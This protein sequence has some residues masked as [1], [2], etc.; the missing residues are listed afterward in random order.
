MQDGMTT[1]Q[2]PEPVCLGTP[3]THTL[4]FFFFLI[5]VL[6]VFTD[7]LRIIFIK[8]CLDSNVVPILPYTEIQRLKVEML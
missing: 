4:N 5:L 6:K 7:R 2:V 8:G 3:K 1:E